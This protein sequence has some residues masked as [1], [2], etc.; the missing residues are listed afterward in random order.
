MG[1]S[2]GETTCLTKATHITHC[3]PDRD[4][5]LDDPLCALLCTVDR[6][7]DSAGDGVGVGGTDAANR[8]FMGWGW[9]ELMQPTGSL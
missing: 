9:E 6:K 7:S 3:G 1:Y 2:G 8:F 4:Q 5:V